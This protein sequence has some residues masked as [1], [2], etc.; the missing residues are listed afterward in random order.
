MDGLLAHWTA[1]T[2]S[3]LPLGSQGRIIILSL[4]EL[5]VEQESQGF[6]KTTII[7]VDIPIPLQ[8][9]GLSGYY[10]CPTFV[11][12]PISVALNPKS[13]NPVKLYPMH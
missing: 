3:I 4:R 1:W 13:L 2:P 6:L 7:T 10:F 5:P 9:L 8:L 11:A 12:I